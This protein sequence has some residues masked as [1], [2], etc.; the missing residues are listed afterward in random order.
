MK[1]TETNSEQWEIKENGV[2]TV[3]V[4]GAVGLGGI[5]LLIW[6]LM[7]LASVAWWWTLVGVGIAAMGAL[8]IFSAASRQIILRRQGLSEVVT[9]KVVGGKQ[10]RLNFDSSQIVSVNLDTSDIVRTDN[11]ARGQTA[12]RERSS[13]LYVLLNDNSEVLLA[14]RK[15]SSDGVSVNG[16]NVTGLSKAPLVDEARRIASF[17]GVPLSSRANNAGGVETIAAAVGAVKQGIAGAQQP[18]VAMSMQP[19][20]QPVTPTVSPQAAASVVTPIQPAAPIVAPVQNGALPTQPSTPEAASV[21]DQ[22]PR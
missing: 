1:I 12:T 22:L 2:I 9:T 21:S 16:F 14:T 20:V 5:G 7:H 3:V 6:T 10:T 18:G 19:Q 17:Y 15:S 4:G 11:D 13:I 8:M